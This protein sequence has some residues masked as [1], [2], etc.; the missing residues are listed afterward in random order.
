MFKAL[1]TFIL[2]TPLMLFAQSSINGKVTGNNKPL[3]AASVFLS[4]TSIGSITD[5]TGAFT[6]NHIKNGQYDLV[7]SCIGYETYHTDVFVSGDNITLPALLLLPKDIALKEVKISSDQNREEHLREFIK[8]FFGTSNNADKCKI[9]NPEL[10]DFKYSKKSKTLKAST[11]DF[12][13]IENKALGYT[14]KYLLQ[15][16]E[17]NET[18]KALYYAGSAIFEPMHG[19]PHEEHRW[20]DNRVD[21]YNGSSMNFLRAC[22]AN[23][24]TDQ[25]FEVFNLIRTKGK[26]VLNALGISKTKPTNSLLTIVDFLKLTEKKGIYAITYPDCLK[27]VY[28]KRDYQATVITFIDPYTFFDSN[29]VVLNPRSNTLEGYW[30]SQRVAEMLPVDYEQPSS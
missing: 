2:L 28:R 30:G 11:D 3:P 29:G 12:L 8:E 22:M 10:I 24:L 13:I 4:N 15:S 26:P 23:R 25:S 17:Y 21:G 19:Q 1:I 16:F 14:I 27:I 7:I 5:S 6:L 9:L 18:T 20:A